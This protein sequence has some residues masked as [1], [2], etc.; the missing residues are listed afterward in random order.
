MEKKNHSGSSQPS[1]SHLQALVLSRIAQGDNPSG[2][3]VREFLENLGIRRSRPAFCI[4][5]GKLEENGLVA[6]S[7][8]SR[9]VEGHRIN[10]RSYSITKAGEETLEF[11]LHWYNELKTQSLS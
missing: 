11:Q 6:G 4:M 7:V 9:L 10:E 3:L 2:T 8:E 5:M 1:L